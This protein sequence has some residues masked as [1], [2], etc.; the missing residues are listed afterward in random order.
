MQGGMSHFSNYWGMACDNVLNFEVSGNAMHII[1][2][3][4]LHLVLWNS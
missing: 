1:C 4:L 2:D 3:A